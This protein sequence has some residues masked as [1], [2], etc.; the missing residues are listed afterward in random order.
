MP[1][2]PG[3]WRV[4]CDRTGDEV[5]ASEVTLEADTGYIVKRGAEEKP[6]PRSHIRSYPRAQRP[7][8][9]IRPEPPDVFVD[10]G[11]FSQGFSMGFRVST[12]PVL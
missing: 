2:R 10:Q 9:D 5:W 8:P 7:L 3:D 1:Y 4:T 11:G 12:T 6:H